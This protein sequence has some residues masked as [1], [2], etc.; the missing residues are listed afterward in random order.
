VATRAGDVWLAAWWK[1]MAAHA[2]VV[3]R[4]GRDVAATTAL[5]LGSYNVLRLLH[6]APVA[7]SGWASWPEPRSSP[8]AG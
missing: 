3:Q 6:E 4:V 8:G 2:Q 5:P 7:A 1:F